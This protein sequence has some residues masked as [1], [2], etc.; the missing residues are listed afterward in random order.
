[1]S[2]YARGYLSRFTIKTPNALIWLRIGADF[3][4][5]FVDCCRDIVFSSAK[6]TQG[7]SH[8]QQY[9][10]C[11]RISIFLAGPSLLSSAS[12]PALAI[13]RMQGS[14]WL[15]MTRFGVCTGVLNILTDFLDFS[16]YWTCFRSK[17]DFMLTFRQMPADAGKWVAQIDSVCSFH[18][19]D[20]YSGWFLLLS[21]GLDLFSFRGGFHDYFRQMQRV[22]AHIARSVLLKEYVWLISSV[23]WGIGL[24]CTSCGFLLVMSRQMRGFVE[25][26]LTQ[27]VVS[28]I[29]SILA[30]FSLLMVSWTC[31]A[32]V[33]WMF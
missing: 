22:Q 32:V 17:M 11:C 31:F 20:W 13:W 16:A 2:C 15:R 26:K 7:C 4:H 19:F 33:Y 21:G 23:C 29:H 14:R 25:P 10:Y 1:M 9:W 18:W 24:V 3:N 27:F 28:M 6:L 12:C 5:R 8:S 30:D